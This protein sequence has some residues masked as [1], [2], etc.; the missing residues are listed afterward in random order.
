MT[1]F[2]Q[3][4]AE[5]LNTE[6]FRPFGRVFEAPFQPGRE[7][8]N[9]FLENSRADARVDLSIATISPL[10]KLPMQATTLERHPYSSQTFIPV[11]VS[12]YLV[13]VAPDYPDGNPNLDRVRC[14]LAKG[15][16]C[17]TYRRGL[18]HHDMTVLD[19][20]TEMAILMWCDRSSNDEELL[21]IDTP[22][23]V[24]LPDDVYIYPQITQMS[25]DNI[26]Q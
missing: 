22:F 8:F 14:F 4:I 10:D 1:R 18:W 11:R 5:P 16:Q 9:E 6:A 21:E 20:I 19:D 17:V 3:V 26:R 13:I 23:E 25:A 2:P 15:N 24:L 7:S 12:R